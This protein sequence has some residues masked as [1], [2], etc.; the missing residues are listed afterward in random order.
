[1]IDKL[2]IAALKPEWSFLKQ[3]FTIKRDDKYHNLYKI[4]DFSNAYLLQTGAGMTKALSTLQE[5]LATSLPASVLHFG[6][7]GSLKQEIQAE[8]L[9]LAQD[10]SHNDQTLTI[11]SNFLTQL[12]SFFEQQPITFHQG[13]LLTVEK[14]LINFEQKEKASLEYKAQCVDME[15]FVIAKFCQERNIP[16]TSVRAIFDGF[17]D[18]IENLGEPYSQEG[19]LKASKLAAN[20]VKSPKLIMQLPALQKRHQRICQKLRKVVHFYLRTNV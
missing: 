16:Y 5:V 12:P 17:E 6:S 2:L 18:N 19:D 11:D 10:I 14:A 1:M 8:D 3:D 9:F 13:T 7:S 20:L 4:T 15:S